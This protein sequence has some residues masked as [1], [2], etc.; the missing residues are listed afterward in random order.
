MEIIIHSHGLFITQY[1][2]RYESPE[3]LVQHEGPAQRCWQ[4]QARSGRRL[5]DTYVEAASYQEAL[6]AALA[7]P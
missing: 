1:G 5:I 3:A 7:R 2:D 4:V 6:A